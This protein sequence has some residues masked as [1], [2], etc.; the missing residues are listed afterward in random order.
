MKQFTL[1]ILTVLIGATTSFGQC[2]DLFFSEY[3]EGSSNNKAMEIYNPTSAAIDLSDYVLY[4]YNNGAVIASDSLFPVGMIAAGDVFI[5]GNPSGAA[6]ILAASDTLH[7][8]TFFNGDDAILLKKISSGDTLDIFGEIGVDPGASWPIGTGATANFT[9]IRKQN[10]QQGQLNWGIGATEWDVFPI[11]MLDSLGT[12]TM[13]ACGTPCTNTASTI[14]PT[15]C[16]SYTAPDGMTYTTSGSYTATIPNLGGCD[17]VITIDLTINT[18]SMSSMTEVACDSFALNG[19]TYTFTGIYTQTLTNAVG[20]DSIITLNLDITHTPMVPMVSGTTEYCDGE[21]PMALSVG[22]AATDS[23]IISGVAD[24]TLTGG[25]PKAVEFYILEDIADLSTYGFGSANNG[26]GTDGEEFTFPAVSVSAG[27]YLHVATDSANFFTFFGFY[28]D[29]THPSAGNVNGDD[30]IELFHN[31]SVI[32]VF[33]D[34]NVDGTGQPWEYQ[35]GWAYRN[36]NAA[37]NGGVFVLGEWLFSG[38]DVLDGAADNASSASPFPIETYT[39]TPPTAVIEW[40]DNAGLTNLVGTG[41]TFTPATIVGTTAYYVTATANGTS[42]CASSAAQ[43]DITFNALPDASVTQVGEVLTADLSGATYQWVNCADTS[44]I[45]GATNQ[46]Y[47]VTAN[48][49]YAVQ[50]TMGGC[51]SLSACYTVDF[52]GLSELLPG[53]KQLV[54]IVDLM[55]RE[56]TFKENTPLIYI[57]SDGSTERIFN[58]KQ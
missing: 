10:I 14:T 49:D 17:S 32:D 58:V 46:T 2:S 16:D 11:D 54:K 24:A 27:T 42:T 3:V 26:G 53:E 40:Y 45:A 29:Y 7:T 34:I 9:L 38:I 21:T 51:T 13:I 37:P 19:T 55:G 36:T 56:T 12:H 30:A 23:M 18:A 43:V 8:L 41:M 35:D 28:P 39:Y 25:L 6:P 52:I 5:F 31:G 1:T 50:V 4:R 22:A 48:G 20:C 47:T 33:G 44:A 15:A 57:Y